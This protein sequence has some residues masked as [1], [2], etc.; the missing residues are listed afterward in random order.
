MKVIKKKKKNAQVKKDSHV[1]NKK[2]RKENLK[3]FLRKEKNEE[4]LNND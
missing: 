3:Q 1:K 4:K 2:K